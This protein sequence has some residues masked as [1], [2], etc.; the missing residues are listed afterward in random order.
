MIGSPGTTETRVSASLRALLAGAID[1]AGLF[2]PA[3]LDLVTAAEHF[4]AYRASADAW[5]LGRF[6]VPAARLAELASRAAALWRDDA[7]SAPTPWRI[8]VLVGADLAGDARRIDDFNDKYG[9]THGETHGTRALVDSIEAVGGDAATI[10]AIASRFTDVER[11]IEIPLGD[12]PRALLRVVAAVGASAKVRT[13]GV[14]ADAIPSPAAVARFIHACAD[15]EVAFKATAG[16]H[17]PL[18]G[19][20]ALTYDADSARGTMFGYL[21]VFVAAMRA[22]EGA[23]EDALVAVLDARDLASLAI[24]AGGAPEPADDRVFAGWGDALAATRAT[25]ALSFGSCSFREPLDDLTSL[26]QR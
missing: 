3:S 16:L 13:G 6:V 23:T 22:R 26:L 9:E 25:F 14:R 11:F 2:P 8:S 19:D 24:A 21:N 7:S 18:R 20:Y 15:I 12:D 5:A 17:H 10:R 1:Y 4:A